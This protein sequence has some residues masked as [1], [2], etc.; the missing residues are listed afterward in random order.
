[1][2]LNNILTFIAVATLLV[3]S[4]GPNG[5]LIAK[6]VPVS[7]R[8]AG[9][10]NICGFVVAFYVHGTLSIL[11]ISMLLVKSS[12]AFFI[13]KM[14]GAAYLVWIGLKA[15]ISA[16]QHNQTQPKVTRENNKIVSLR[17][18]FLE[19]LITNVLN[20]KVSMFYLAAFPQFMPNTESPI[21]AYALVTAHSMVN[22]VW[23]A[24][25]VMVLSK[26][27]KVTNSAKFK[28]WLNSITGLVFIA[29]GLKLALMKNG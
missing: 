17:V 6:T 12:Q 7:G 28:T 13:F 20:P 8:K 27:K 1:M 21:S 15:I 14:L 18:A 22:F 11:G 24:I 9:F 3:I 23:F 10:A 25:M 2:D 16:F 26:V 19:G 29:F 5:F 4:P